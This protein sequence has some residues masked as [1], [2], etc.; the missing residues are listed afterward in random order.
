MELGDW[1]EMPGDEEKGGSKERKEKKSQN[2]D[3]KNGF[4]LVYDHFH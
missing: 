3:T 4:L 1:G 2:G